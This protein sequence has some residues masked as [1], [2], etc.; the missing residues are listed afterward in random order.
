MNEEELK[1]VEI[2]FANEETIQKLISEYKRLKC[3]KACKSGGCKSKMNNSDTEICHP[4][5]KE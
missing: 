1:E 3:H 2:R 4:P 5:I